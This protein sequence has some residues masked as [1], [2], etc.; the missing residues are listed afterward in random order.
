[1]QKSGPPSQPDLIN[2]T[3]SSK[4]PL[5][6]DPSKQGSS[7]VAS[8][9]PP[10]P[11]DHSSSVPFPGH[12]LSHSSVPPLV[13]PPSSVSS[14]ILSGQAQ[15]NSPSAQLPKLAEGGAKDPIKLTCHQCNKH[16]NTKPLL[17]SH[18]VRHGFNYLTTENSIPNMTLV[19]LFPVRAAFLCC[20]VLP[21][22]KSI[23][24][25]K[26]SL[27]CVRAASR[28]RG[29]LTPSPTTRRSFSSV[30]KVRNQQF[31]TLLIKKETG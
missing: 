29:F 16:F 18:Q 7:A 13:P 4:D 8:S 9:V 15:A 14:P 5:P 24:Q 21:V 31:H 23:K 30:V 27:W 11:Q 2:G 26:T 6:K 22:L 17:F 3:S 28:R 12:H 10:T 20:A 25:R 1:M 19:R